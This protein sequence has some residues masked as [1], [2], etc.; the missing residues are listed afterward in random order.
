MTVEELQAFLMKEQKL[1][2]D[3]QKVKELIRKHEVSTIKEELLLTMAGKLS[4][5]LCRLLCFFLSVK[6][7]SLV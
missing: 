2:M 5:I 1:T 4:R 6:Q 3:S 7:G